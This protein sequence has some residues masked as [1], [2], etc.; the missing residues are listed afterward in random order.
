[1]SRSDIVAKHCEEVWEAWKGDLC[2]VLS[3]TLLRHDS[4]TPHP[5]VEQSS[6]G[7]V[8]R[9]SISPDDIES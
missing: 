1:M 2:I 5:M 3:L 9:V 7:G 6:V 8:D 4:L